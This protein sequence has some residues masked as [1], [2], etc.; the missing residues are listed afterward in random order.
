MK[1]YRTILVE[2]QNGEQYVFIC[3]QRVVQLVFGCVV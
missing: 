2:S 3:I 1:S